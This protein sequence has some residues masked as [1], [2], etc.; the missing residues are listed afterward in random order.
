M[1]IRP[2]PN[3]IKKQIPIRQDDDFSA[4]YIDE[5][6]NGSLDTDELYTTEPTLSLEDFGSTDVQEL[7]DFANQKSVS[8]L[9]SETL[10]P[11]DLE[12]I[13]RE[14]EDSDD[15]QYT[16]LGSLDAYA[17]S[18]GG[19]GWVIDPLPNRPGEMELQILVE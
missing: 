7:K 19:S 2:N 9:T 14:Y 12:T 17:K 16:S 13:E 3:Q 1:N 5:D 4:I 10:G 11:V 8:L 6:N 15:F 18:N